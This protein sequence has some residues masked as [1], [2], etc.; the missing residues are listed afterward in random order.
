MFNHFRKSILVFDVHYKLYG[1]T[2]LFSCYFFRC[3]KLNIN[4]QRKRLEGIL[5]S[6]EHTRIGAASGVPDTVR[7]LGRSTT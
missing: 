1:L 7:C 5:Q 3:I 4:I 2:S 6:L